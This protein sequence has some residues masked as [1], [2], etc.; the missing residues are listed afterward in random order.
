MRRIVVAAA[1]Q[2]YGAILI[3]VG[4]PIGV[5]EIRHGVSKVDFWVQKAFRIAL[6]AHFA[7][8]RIFDLHEAKAMAMDEA[9]LITALA[10]D[11]AMDQGLWNAMNLAWR[12]IIS[13]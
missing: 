3:A 4:E 8:R 9:R 11:D 2:R 6:I 12:A 10:L 7:R 13:S 5:G 1:E